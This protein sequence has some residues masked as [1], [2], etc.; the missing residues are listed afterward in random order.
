M[1]LSH[2]CRGKILNHGWGEGQGEGHPGSCEAGAGLGPAGWPCATRAR[3]DSGSSEGEDGPGLLGG[4]S[5][6]SREK[7]G[8]VSVHSS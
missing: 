1:A 4:T 3:E 8:V 5:P 7:V 2:G 6:G